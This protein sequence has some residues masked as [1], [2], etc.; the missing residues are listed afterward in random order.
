MGFF[1]VVLIVFSL[2]AGAISDRIGR[3][4]V[5]VYSSILGAFGAVLM[6]FAV[7]PVQLI[8]FSTFLGVGL[9]MFLSTNWA[10]ANEMAP[11]AEAGNTWV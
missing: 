6:I 2:L 8:A 3:K 11:A 9:G 4:K 7:T 1:V 5:Q 10:L